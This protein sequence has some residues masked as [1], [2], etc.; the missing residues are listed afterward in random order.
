MICKDSVEEKILQLQQK[1]KMLADD[2]IQED[3]NFVKT[4][5]RD[6]I[7]FLFG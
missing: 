6:D 1:K 4:L 5:S 3:A 2:L 7:E